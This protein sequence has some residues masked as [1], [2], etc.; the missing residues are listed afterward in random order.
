MGRLKTYKPDETLLR[1][2]AAC[3]RLGID[4]LRVP[5]VLGEILEANKSTIFRWAMNQ[6]WPSSAL[7]VLDVLETVPRKF[8]PI[9]VSAPIERFQEKTAA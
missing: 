6:T 3:V 2:E 5:D 9:R 1:L 7:I 8:W 4:K